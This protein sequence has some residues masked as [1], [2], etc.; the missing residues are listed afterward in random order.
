[1]P[2]ALPLI[3]TTLGFAIIIP[4]LCFYLENHKKSLLITII[5]GSLIPLVFYVVWELVTLGALSIDGKYGLMSLAQIKADGSFRAN[6]LPK[7]AFYG[8]YFPYS[9]N[10]GEND[11]VFSP[12]DG[13]PQTDVNNPNAS[14]DCAFRTPRNNDNDAIRAA[15]S[16]RLQQYPE[17]IPNPRDQTGRAVGLQGDYIFVTSANRLDIQNLYL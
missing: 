11:G 12:N 8:V 10:P 9:G 4:S 5:V 3:I 13:G 1:M 15:F 17:T 6:G 14:P 16:Y 7:A 2:V